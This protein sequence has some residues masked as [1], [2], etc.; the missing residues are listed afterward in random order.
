MSG[1]LNTY[2]YF[3]RIYIDQKIQGH[4]FLA[5][6]DELQICLR[7]RDGRVWQSGCPDSETRA[8]SQV[9]VCP[10][11]GLPGRAARDT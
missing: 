1:Q 7:G 8:P 9:P 5:T 2:T 10:E 3:S 4:F 11:G 6:I